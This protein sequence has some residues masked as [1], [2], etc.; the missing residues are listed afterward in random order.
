MNVNNFKIVLSL[1]LLLSSAHINASLK[2]N[3]KEQKKPKKIVISQ[4][5]LDIRDDINKTWNAIRKEGNFYYL[6][7]AKNKVRP[8]YKTRPGIVYYK[9]HL[10]DLFPFALVDNKVFVPISTNVGESGIYWKGKKLSCDKSVNFARPAP[11][12]KINKD[13]IVNFKMRYNWS[14]RDIPRALSSGQDF[15]VNFDTKECFATYLGSKSVHQCHIVT[16]SELN[17]KNTTNSIYRGLY[18]NKKNLETCKVE[19]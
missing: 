5:V 12:G 17:R 9:E 2:D 19:N 1:S 6:M 18:L 15:E 16:F 8:M 4:E 14:S 3:F 13:S 11:V 10:S 7:N